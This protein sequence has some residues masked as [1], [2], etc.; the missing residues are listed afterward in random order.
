V[1][2]ST[3]LGTGTVAIENVLVRDC[4]NAPLPGNPGAAASVAID[5][6]GPAPPSSV[7]ASPVTLGNDA[8]GTTK[9]GIVIAA[10]VEPGGRVEVWRRG[11]GNY[12]AYD[13]GAS[14]GAV[15]AMPVGY[16]PSGWTQTTVTASGQTDEPA[17]RDFWY[18]VAYLLDA[19]GN[20]TASTMTGGTLNYVLGDVHD[21]SAD[22]A[23][24]NHVDT[25]DLTFFGAHYG[26][27]L[28]P[29]DGLRCLDFGPTSTGYVDG[30][31]LTDNR[32]NF[33]DLVLFAINY[34]AVTAPALASG[35]RPMAASANALGLEVGQPSAVGGTF[36]AVLRFEGAGDVQALSVTL[37]YDRSVVDPV[38]VARG[39]LL[40]QQA[41]PAEMFTPAPG[42]MDFAVF[43]Q[44]GA[45]TGT[46]E[47][48]RVTFRTRAAGNPGIAL[49]AVSARDTRNR[50]VSLGR[51]AADT[52][53]PAELPRAVELAPSYPNPVTHATT[54]VFGVPRAGVAKLA[55]FDIQ[56]RAVRHLV[57]GALG[58]G[59]QRLSWDGR[60]DAGNAVL[61]GAYVIRLSVDDRT[62]S[63]PVRLVR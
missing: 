45:L 1:G 53:P 43:G 38:A 25:S 60:D 24:D 42:A 55:V 59:W 4:S 11:F 51:V 7:S 28:G 10:S 31:P 6:T 14:P 54:V 48:A 17:T 30:R 44:G 46:G 32:V 29:A 39:S 19:A 22:C 5:N 15:P 37:D 35:A 33:E 18:Y 13:E 52:R 23:G 62:I 49:G 63:K 2:S 34:G 8:D 21:A 16:P 58:A 50:P 26:A 61:P 3:A 47:I 9:I 57:D 27:W 20:A 41:G 36:E 40:S 12:P 56:G